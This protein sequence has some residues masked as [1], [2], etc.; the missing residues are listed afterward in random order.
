MIKNLV[1]S[2]GGLKT[3]PILGALK[4][5]EDK[6]VLQHITSYFTTSA[7][8]VYAL[9]LLLQYTIT[10]IENV[11]IKFEPSKILTVNTNIDNFLENFNCY[12]QDTFTKF[13]KLL[14]S[15]KLGK[16]FCDITLQELF[17]KT[18]KS[19]L[20]ATISLKTKNLK[21]FNHINQP[22]L[23]VY[24]LILMTC[25]IPLIFK[26]V[27][28]EGDKYI[29]G[30]LIDN[31]PLFAI[32]PN[33]HDITLGIY[34]QVKFLKT[35]V[36]FTDII[37]YLTCLMTI[38]SM[39]SRQLPYHNILTVTVKEKHGTSYLNL[40]MSDKEK[41]NIIAKGYHDSEKQYLKILEKRF[42][43]KTIIRRNSF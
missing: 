43:K 26:P 13:I 9:M 12:E 23:P 17:L 14:I 11:M 31:F 15:F 4:M 20:C 36:K 35:N 3:I 40:K 37:D 7:G 39:S 29:D 1:I 34:A 2:G 42:S 25:A 8:S 30:G 10:D 18:N 32:P 28:W 5:L 33:E 38:S 21:F 16:E 22:N 6:K 27:S 19:L 41:Q 24:K